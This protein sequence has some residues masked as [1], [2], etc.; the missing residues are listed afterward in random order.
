MSAIYTLLAQVRRHPHYQRF[1]ASPKNK[2]S[3]LLGQAVMTLANNGKWLF[4]VSL[5]TFLAFVFLFYWIEPVSVVSA[6][7][8]AIVNAFTQGTQAAATSGGVILEIFYIPW[9][10]LLV[11]LIGTYVLARV[12]ISIN[13]YTDEEQQDDAE[14]DERDHRER[15][16]LMASNL[17][18]EHALG[19]LPRTMSGLPL[20]DDYTPFYEVLDGKFVRCRSEQQ[21]DAA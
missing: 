20:P 8:W 11:L 1:L 3:N 16:M 19:T 12:I 2:T 10:F 15:A 18:I 13:E 17:R 6:F 5:S 7:H 4:R 14:A 9:A 21:P